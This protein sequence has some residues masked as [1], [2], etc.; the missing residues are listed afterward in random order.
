MDLPI[1]RMADQ[2][3]KNASAGFDAFGGA[4]FE[5]MSEIQT[6]SSP[7]ITPMLRSAKS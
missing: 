5:A 4:A 6:G 2:Y 1:A 3:L 7:V